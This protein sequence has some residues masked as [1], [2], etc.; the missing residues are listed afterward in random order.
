M[1]VVL[2]VGLAVVWFGQA[3]WLSRVMNG[4]G[5][6]PLPWFMVPL[7]IGPAV[8]PLALIEALSGPPAPELLRRGKRGP[9]A[10]DVFVLL[11]DDHVPDRIEAELQRLMPRCRHLVLARVIK[12]GGPTA[13]QADAA[14]F[15]KRI[16]TPPRTRDAELQLHFGVASRVI[17]E[18]EARGD[19][20]FLLRSSQASKQFY[21]DGGSQ[22]ERWT[23]DVPAA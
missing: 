12:A 19:V 16:T 3:I 23:H 7:L 9:G 8:W 20:D 22:E 17:T 1:S 6:H 2:V 13:I 18:I 21:S 4:R 15:L 5:F 14:R 10:L 11:E